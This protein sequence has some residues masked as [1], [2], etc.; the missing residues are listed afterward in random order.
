MLAISTGILVT[1]T[2]LGFGVGILLVGG[3]ITYLILQNRKEKKAADLKARRQAMQNNPHLCRPPN[4]SAN[5]PSG[6]MPRTSK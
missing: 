6:Q 5:P 3:G 2:I 4:L 1:A